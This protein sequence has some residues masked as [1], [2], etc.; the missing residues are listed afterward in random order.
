MQERFLVQRTNAS[1]QDKTVYLWW[2]PLTYTADFQTTGSTWLA[3]NQ[4]SKNH[5]LSIPIQKD[6]WLIVN[7]DQPGEFQRGKKT[8]WRNSRF[9]IG[10]SQSTDKNFLLLCLTGY[11][12]V[13]YD[14]QNWKLLA[15]Q[16][17]TNHTAISVI[18]RAQ[19]MDD[20][21]NLAEAGILD[22]DTALDLTRYLEN[23]KEYVPWDA[24]LNSM[25]YIASMMSR[26]S[27]YGLLK[28]RQRPFVIDLFLEV[29]PYWSVYVDS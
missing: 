11:Y 17:L 19:I 1:S 25:G 14:S 22:Y 8:H 9:A 27:G 20:A 15:Q 26:T 21:L 6:Q 16:L 13:N 12:R 29:T 23:E 4:T 24:A 3:D 7:V 18:N 5:E 10:H 28:V 2:V